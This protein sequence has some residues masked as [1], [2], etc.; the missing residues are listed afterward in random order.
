MSTSDIIL[1]ILSGL[2]VIH[3]LFL[4]I[5]LW[6]Y[7]KGNVL[8]NK[9]LGLLL[10]VLSFRIGKSV[11]LEF[12]ENLDVSL[13]FT[14]LGA[15][16]ILGPLYY[17][18][19][20]SCSD[21]TFTFKRI[22]LLHFIPAVIGIGF[23]LWVNMEDLE[24]A[25]KA[26]IISLFASYYGH[27]LTYLIISYSYARR[28]RK[29]SLNKGVYDFIR[30]LFFGFLAIWV[31]YVLN[32]F[33]EEVPYIIGPI[34]Y[35]LVAYTISFI[36]I[37]KGYIN[38]IDH[39]KYQTTAIS[40]Q[41]SDE[42]FSKV[43]HLMNA[44]AAF[45]NTDLTL[46]ALSE[47]LKVSTQALSMVIN[48]KSQQNFNSFVNQYRIEEA[49]RLFNQREF[50]H[51]TIAAIAFEV[52]FNSISSFNTAFKKQTGKTPLAYRKQLSE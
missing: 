4:A 29:T 13:I 51:Q 44:E 41:Q 26:W 33:D 7:G 47:K 9:L 11:F 17:L 18:F 15:I 22:H 43:L 12:T 34:L 42:L 50:D 31:V 52:G 39:T 14:G 20:V 2:G 28:K 48:Q 8:S 45:K 36:V 49:I 25:P 21:K 3:G 24:A 32:L 10:V 27:F 1:V 23:G 35:S 6:G 16:F 37:R 5:F 46:K 40:G 30:L 19:V 38:A